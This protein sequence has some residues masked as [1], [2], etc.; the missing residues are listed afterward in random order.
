MSFYGLIVSQF[1]ILNFLLAKTTYV[2]NRITTTVIFIEQPELIKSHGYQV[3]IHNVVTEDG[4]ILEIHRLPYGRT[5]DQR[6]FNNG[7]QPVLIQH[8]LVGSSADWILMGPGRSLPY[9]LVDAGYDVWLGNNRGNVYS[10]SHISLL[11]TDRHFWNFSYH[12]LGMYDVP[13]TIDYIINQTNCEQ[14]F[15]IG[16]SQGTTQFWV[17]MSQKPDYNAK[18]KLMISLAPVA[19]TGNLRGPIII[20]VKLLYLTVQISE[21]LGYSEIYSKS[22]FEDNYQD[23]S[24]KFFIQN[25]IFSFAGFNRTSVNATDLA[26]IMNDIP[27][28]ASW[29]EL[30]HFSQ[31]YIYPGNF[32]QFDYGNDEKNYRMYNSVQPPEYK[33]D[34]IIAPIAFFSS[35]DDIIATKP[36]VSLLKTKL[37]NLVFHKEISIKSFSHYDFLWAPSAMSVVFK[38]TLDLL[39]LYD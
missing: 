24:I 13:A 30:V 5:N 15:Y 11:P 2:S 10:K 19:F 14:I 12:E 18:I 28:G 26:S 35:V 37:H 33:L 3:E 7:K 32:R 23:I 36:D 8:G 39:V 20:L 9:M 25:M 1:L 16:H 29:K 17:T 22:I 27:A 4:Y 31:G 34:K 21:D 38:P 6:N